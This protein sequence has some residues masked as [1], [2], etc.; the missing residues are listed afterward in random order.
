MNAVLSAPVLRGESLLSAV[1]CGDGRSKMAHAPL[2]APDAGEVLVRLHGCGVCA[3]NL[4]V[5]EG[6]EWFEY[7]LEAGAPGHEGWGEVAAMGEGVQGLAVGDRV[8]LLSQHAY[9]SHDFAPATMLARIPDRV[10]VRQLPGEPLAC[11][12]NILRRSAVRAGQWV[13]VVGVGFIG[14]LVVQLAAHAGAKVIAL[15]RREWALGM[16]RQCGAEQAVNSSDVM[17]AA[18]TVRELTGGAGCECVIEAAGEQATLDLATALCAEGGRL[19]IAG[20]H[21]DGSRQVDMQ[22]WNWRGLDVINAHERNPAVVARGLR[23]AM[24]AVADGVL[25]P[26][27]LITHSVPLAELGRAFDLMRQRPDGFM[28]AVVVP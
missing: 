7:P 25:D 13:A 24:A 16:A 14:A 6:R 11:A 8:A 9:A 2:R 23:E 1:F 18:G 20:Y 17:S 22:Q 19:V 3:S 27:P 5:W 26:F 21:Q 10:G 12:V 4:P 28:K 15:T